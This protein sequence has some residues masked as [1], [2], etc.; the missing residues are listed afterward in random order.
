MNKKM[1]IGIATVVS[2]LVIMIVGVVGYNTYFR[3]PTI[4]HQIK[5]KTDCIACHGQNGIK[6]YPKWHAEDRYGNEKC[7]TCHHVAG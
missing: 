3:P 1:K 7:A 5:G 2:V 6:P 4:P